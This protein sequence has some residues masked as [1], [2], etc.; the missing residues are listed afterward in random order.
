MRFEQVMPQNY[1]LFQV[2]DDL[3]A[4][5]FTVLMAS[6]NKK[7]IFSNG[8]KIVKSG[9]LYFDYFI[10]VYDNKTGELADRFRFNIEKNSFVS[11]GLPLD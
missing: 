7:L 2:F 1:V 4:S 9:R 3:V 6:T 10:F 11:F 8:R 5:R